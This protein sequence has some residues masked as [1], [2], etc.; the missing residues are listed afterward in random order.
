MILFNREWHTN[1]K[2][3]QTGYSHSR[4][5]SERWP[6]GESIIHGIDEAQRFGQCCQLLATDD[7]SQA[8]QCS[9]QQEAA[10]R[11]QLSAET[12]PRR[13]G[14][15]VFAPHE[16]HQAAGNAVQQGCPP[17]SLARTSC[18]LAI[19]RPTECERLEGARQLSIHKRG[20]SVKCGSIWYSSRPQRQEVD[21]PWEAAQLTPQWWQRPRIFDGN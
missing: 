17:C 7:A 11:E 12:V 16:V 2:R 21:S 13:T 3:L 4:R 10:P 19:R 15:P 6:R 18:W 5:D 8:A 9:V 20:Q 14:L 1:S